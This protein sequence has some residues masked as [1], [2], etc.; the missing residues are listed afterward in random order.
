MRRPSPA[1]CK[2][3]R[4]ALWRLGEKYH[5]PWKTSGGGRRCSLRRVWSAA[6]SSAYLSAA[7]PRLP[8]VL[9]QAAASI[10]AMEAT[11]WA[12]LAPGPGEAP[13]LRPFMSAKPRQLVVALGWRA[14][15][16]PPVPTRGA[17]CRSAGAREQATRCCRRLRDRGQPHRVRSTVG[18][19][20]RHAGTGARLTTPS[21][22]GQCGRSMVGM[23][24]RSTSL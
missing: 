2:T 11:H 16:S 4:Q 18:C 3:R 17:G 6:P 19:L 21:F 1:Q 13:C 10:L 12:V 14:V 24:S 22:Q 8:T 9:A 23:R 15:C 20:A 5:S 7:C